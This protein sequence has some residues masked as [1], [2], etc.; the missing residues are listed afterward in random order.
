M[1][2]VNFSLWGDK[3]I[4]YRGVFSNYE[5]INKLLPSYEM[6]VYVDVNY[7]HKKLEEIK[8]LN[9]KVNLEVP[10]GSYSGMYWRFYACNDCADED[11]SLIRDLDSRITERESSLINM[12]EL[13]SLKV[14]IIR[15]HFHHNIP[16]MGGLWGCKGRIHNMRELI[17]KY[18]HFNGY[19]VDQHFLKDCIFPLIKND[20][21]EYTSNGIHFTDTYLNISKTKDGSFIGE[22]IDEQELPLVIEHRIMNKEVQ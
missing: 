8:K 5:L 17:Q 7:N 9:I 13:S 21:L 6:V 10:N 19:G 15:D 20:C 2:T 12:W 18:G 14:H 11:I 22:R 3:E 16:M 4:Y 1:K